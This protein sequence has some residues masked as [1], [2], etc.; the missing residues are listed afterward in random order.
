M[1]PLIT[2]HPDAFPS[3]P[4]PDLDDPRVVAAHDW[5]AFDSLTEMQDHWQRPGWTSKTRAFYWL[6]TIPDE[7]DF[8][9]QA[10]QCQEA[11]RHFQAFDLIDSD[12]FHLTLGRIADVDTVNERLLFSLAETVQASAPAAFTLSALP[13]TGSRGALRY[14]VAPWTPVIR[15]HELLVAASA[16]CGLPPM[17]S[18][19]RLR[20]HIGIGYCDRTLPTGPVHDVLRILRAL[21]PTALEIDH[22]DLV[23]MRREGA[24][25]RWRVVQTVHLSH[26]GR[27]ATV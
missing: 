26:E 25:Y 22:V 11:V 3:A 6:L 14:S 24:S 1:P 10:R 16:S 9:A 15:L 20:P 19:S 17:K 21:S 4:P 12:S 23:E 13:L 18:S 5:R 2:S 27:K 7:S 8:A